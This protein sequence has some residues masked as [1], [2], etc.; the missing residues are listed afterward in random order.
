MDESIAESINVTQS[1]RPFALLVDPAQIYAAAERI[2][3][4]EL[5]KVVVKAF[6]SDK[7]KPVV[8]TRT[9]RRAEVA[10]G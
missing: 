9:N 2:A 8:K 4:L 7:E 6:S 1:N 3:K 10:W 5:P